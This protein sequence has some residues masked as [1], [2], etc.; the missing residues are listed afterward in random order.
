MGGSSA[1]KKDVRGLPI[2]AP[3]SASPQ[4]PDGQLGLGS[5][6]G[7]HTPRV[8]SGIPSPM[9]PRPLGPRG[10]GAR[11]SFTPPPPPPPPPPGG[12]TGPP[13]RASLDTGPSRM[14]VP[15]PAPASSS[16]SSSPRNLR[17]SMDSVRLGGKTGGT[18]GMLGTAAT[19]MDSGED[20]KY[21]TDVLPYVEKS[22]LRAYL[23]RYGGDQM[24]ALG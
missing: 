13:G 18:A 23:K 14:S 6:L 7:S 5:G 24:Q 20:V 4:K 17:G 11:G 22:V 10:A 15:A 1:S 12:Q 21:M 2:S 9:G 16:S 3:R 8:Q 19:G